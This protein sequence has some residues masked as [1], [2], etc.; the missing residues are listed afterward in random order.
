MT[1]TE[2]GATG[3]SA[4]TRP[5]YTPGGGDA[6]VFLVAF[7]PDITELAV[8]QADHRVDEVPETLDLAVQGAD[9]VAAFLEPPIGDLLREEQPD[10]VEIAA[11]SEGCLVIRGAIPD[12]S[13]LLYLRS[14]IGIATAALDAGAVAIYNLQSF[15]FFGPAQWRHDVFEPDRPSPADFVVILSSDD[16]EG[17]PDGDLWLHTRGMR[18]FGRPDI[19]VHGVPADQANLGGVLVRSLIEQ[20]V[21]G[22]RIEEGSTMNVGDPLGEITFHHRGHIDDPEFN[23]VHLAIDWPT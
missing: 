20:Q 7:G 21:K 6:F 12:P 18:V 3:L 4:W 16:H 9:A 10:L 5:L 14:V 13:D 11:Q 8:S 17:G 19:S 2:P 15:G 23:N 22:L 1:A